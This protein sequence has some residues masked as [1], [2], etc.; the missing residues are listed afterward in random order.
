MEAAVLLTKIQ[1]EMQAL[2]APSSVPLPVRPIQCVPSIVF[3]SSATILHNNNFV[4]F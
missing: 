1:I 4:L 3:S 2:C